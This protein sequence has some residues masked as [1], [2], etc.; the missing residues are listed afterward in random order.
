MIDPERNDA[1]KGA[2]EAPASVG[3]ALSAGILYRLADAPDGIPAVRLGPNRGRIY[4]PGRNLLAYIKGS[5]AP[6]SPRSRTGRS[7]RPAPR[8]APKDD[9]LEEFLRAANLL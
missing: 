3:V 5:S 4:F 7:P 1:V 8:P 2:V 6:R 9:S